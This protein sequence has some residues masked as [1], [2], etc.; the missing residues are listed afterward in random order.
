[1][2]KSISSIISLRASNQWNIHTKDSDILLLLVSVAAGSRQSH[3]HCAAD[4]DQIFEGPH[5]AIQK[6][7]CRLLTGEE[8]SSME[9]EGSGTLIDEDLGCCGGAGQ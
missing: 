1:M 3:N 5:A 4:Q 8:D 6:R 7:K 2:P 9:L